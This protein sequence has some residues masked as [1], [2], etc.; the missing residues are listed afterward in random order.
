MLDAVCYTMRQMASGKNFI[1]LPKAKLPSFPSKKNGK[2]RR[3]NS[4]FKTIGVYVLIGL[5]ILVFI[6]SFSNSGIGGDEI[7]LSQVINEIKEEKVEKVSLE[8]EK[9]MVDYKQ[10]LPAEA[11][12]DSDK[13]AQSRKEAGES[14]YRIFESAGVDPSKVNI[15]IKDM[16][17]QQNW[18]S[19][20]G[21]VLPI[22]VMVGFFL[23]IFRQAKDGAQGIFSFGPSRARL[24]TKYQ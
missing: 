2:N 13:T 3:V 12:K 1:K 18:V 16:S 8:G 11:G 10:S 4:I 20:I 19:I 15:E 6:S 21:T 23:L 24:F 14:I 9:V 7:P 22:L 17:W 5:S